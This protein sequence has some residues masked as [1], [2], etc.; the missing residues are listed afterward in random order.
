MWKPILHGA[1]RN[2][3]LAA[4]RAV[5]VAL[6]GKPQRRIGPCLAGGA[7]GLSILYP[8]LSRSLADG[9]DDEIAL[10]FLKQAAQ[11]VSRVPMDRSFYDGFAGVAWSV[12]HLRAWLLDPAD[13]STAPVDQLLQSE[14]N[15]KPWRGQYDLVSGLVGFGVYALEQMPKPG[16][17]QC[18][19]QIIDRLDESAERK[20]DGI[21]WF[22]SRDMLFQ[23]ERSAH[24]HGYYNLGLAH[25]VPGVIALLGR[26]CLLKS[27]KATAVSKIQVKARSLLEGTV[28][29]LLAQK[30]SPDSSSVFPSCTGPGVERIPSRV[31][32]C[33]GDLGIAIALLTAAL[34]TNNAAWKD[35]AL[36]LGRKVARRPLRESRVVDSGLCHGAAGVGHLFNR[37]FQRTGEPL[38]KQA[39]R[40]WFQHTLDM[41]RPRQSVAGFF[42][43]RRGRNGKLRCVP[44]AG[45]LEGA[46][47]VALALL[48]ASTDIE[49]NWDRMLMI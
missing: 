35:E 30:L 21:T 27:A 29:W 32:W 8:Y 33:Y 11:A 10:R 17:I 16:A 5:A 39:A 45:L 20:S 9:G 2:K 47:G 28:P 48:A 26:V 22:T 41:R 7:A 25:G 46:A 38:F 15:E 24:P 19:R 13:D 3:A 37:I 4:V 14:L 43:K 36:Q 31:A 1:L 34:S 44:T 6:S 12:A 42:S 18:L 49:P 40:K 23:S